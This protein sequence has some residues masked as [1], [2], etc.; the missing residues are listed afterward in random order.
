MCVVGLGHVGL[1]TAALLVLAEVGGQGRVIE[2][3][4]VEP[5]V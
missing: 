2:P 5:G 3:A 1:P 4:A